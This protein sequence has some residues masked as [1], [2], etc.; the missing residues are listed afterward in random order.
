M[1]EDRRRSVA[2]L[3]LP[4]L[5]W[6]AVI[7]YGSSQQSLP[8]AAS[9]TLDLLIKKS[10]HV[11]EYA[12]LGLLATRAWYG[13]LRLT[14]GAV[15]YAQW[16]KTA[17]MALAVG[18]LYAVSD[19]IHQ[20]FV[21]TRNGHVEDIILDAAAVTLGVGLMWLWRRLWSRRQD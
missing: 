1:R 9:G 11:I 20:L 10:G 13:T 6:M 3:W 21:P 14:S 17:I 16:G 4:V 15:S 18:C 12:L 7:F 5:I 8:T 2:W 19:E